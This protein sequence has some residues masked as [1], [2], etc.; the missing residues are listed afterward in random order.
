MDERLIKVIALMDSATDG[1][2]ASAFNKARGLLQRDGRRFRDLL[3]NG[4]A[5]RAAGDGGGATR[6]REA[7]EVLALRG[8]VAELERQLGEA[9]ARIESAERGLSLVEEHL[10]GLH[11]RYRTALE[12]KDRAIARLRRQLAGVARAGQV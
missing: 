2:A 6:R 3:G 11:R 10:D 8:R 4:A 12:Q 7:A 5:G 9:H 1:E